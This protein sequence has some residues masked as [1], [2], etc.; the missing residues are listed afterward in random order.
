LP[1]GIK[2]EQT[3]GTLPIWIGRVTWSPSGELLA[4]PSGSGS[5]WLAKPHARKEALCIRNAHSGAVFTVAFGAN[6]ATIATGAED[7]WVKV[8]NTTTG[9]LLQ[10][11]HLKSPVYSVAF[12]SAGRHLAVGT[13]DRNVYVC[14]ASNVKLLRILGRHDDWVNCLAFAPGGRVLF[15]GSNDG[16]VHMWDVVGNRLLRKL[17]GHSRAVLGIAFHPDGSRLASASADATIKLWNGETGQVIATLEGHT[18]E[19]NCVTFACEGRV[20]ASKSLDNTFRVWNPDAGSCIAVISEP[21]ST[22]WAPGIAGHPSL[23]W[24]A[25]VGSK[26]NAPKDDPA[27][28]ATERDRVVHI[29][30][31]DPDVLR[32]NVTSPTITYTSAKVVLVGES[33]VGK[34]YLAHRIATGATPADGTIKSTHGMKFW[35]LEPDQLSSEVEVPAGERRDIVL[36]DMGGQ[37]EY[38]LI[39]QLFLHDTTVALVLLDPTRGTAAFKEVMTWNKH[40]DNQLRGRPAVKLL[41][42]SKLDEPS[43]TI[44]RKGL[45]R[46]RTDCGFAEYYETSALTGRGVT[47]MCN[48][49]AKAID[50]TGLGKTSRPKL[51]QFIRDEIEARRKRGDVVLHLAELYRALRVQPTDREARAVNAVT[52]QLA[53]QGV[54]ARSSVATGEPALVLQV[55]EVERY[56]GSLIVAARNNPRGVAAL[57]LAAIVRR[58]FALPGIPA[59]ERLPPDQ[60]LLVLECTVQLLLAHGICFKHEGLLVFPT[61]FASS[62]GD[63]AQ[64]MPHSVSLYYDFS[65]AIDNIYASL[66]AWL[67][68]A[69]DFGKVR[70]A[71]DRAE[72]EVQDS[73]LYGL[74]KVPRPGGFAHVDVFFGESV[75]ESQRRR[76]INF[77]DDHLN[78][79]GVDIREHVEVTCRCGKTFDEDTVRQRIARGERD[80]ICPICETRNRLSEGAKVARSEDPEV[81]KHTWALKTEIGLRREKST[82]SAVQVLAREARMKVGN[83]PIR[84]LHLSDLHFRAETPVRARLQWLSDDLRR[85]EGW[86]RR[87]IERLDYL[88]IS[89]DF[90]DRGKADG[91]ERAYEF[92][93]MLSQTFNLSAERCV[94]VPGNH[95]IRDTHDS[96]DWRTSATGLADGAWVQQ[97]AIVLARNKEKY[98]LRLK[99]FSDGFYHKF[100]QRPYPTDYSEQGLV[101]PFWETGLQF[102]TF[103]SCWEIDQFHRSR[104]G[105]HPEAVARALDEAQR[106]EVAARHSSEL[107]GRVLRIA[108]WHH[109]IAGPEQMV[110]TDFVGHLQNCGVKIALHG[111]V[112]ELR[113]DLVGQSRGKVLHVVGAGSFGASKDQRPDAMPRLYNLIELSRDLGSA[114]VHTRQQPKPDGPWKGWNEWPDPKGGDGAVSFYDIDLK[115][116]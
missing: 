19:I 79:H 113:R 106:Q 24:L 116:D 56:A 89:G 46:L 109:A 45:E 102:L 81:E 74:R 72:F 78:Q 25:T 3:I 48:A 95:D 107:K 115:T 112:H 82:T 5:V 47:E 43:E 10:M 67:V 14:D 18:G 32:N 33:N 44:D 12:D 59:E 41:V 98:P 35:P 55:Q 70:L 4:L 52:E 65:G 84:V 85:G 54:I 105:V 63:V 69:Q 110:N 57:E 40:L 93:S 11:F 49:A 111:D 29:W 50:W 21:A 38:R 60:E 91:F 26:W 2:L 88:V 114:R 58:G 36:W 80:V 101:I 92:V 37:D 34:S 76:F 77:V 108:V 103:N 68:L 23:P 100:L 75:P 17:H 6:G 20:L 27:S 15:S 94:F 28:L 73:G 97:G 66:V 22:F 8:W 86:G 1:P 99:Q 83:A 62:A 96:Y 90:T 30:K 9:E 61:C 71:G 7:E 51:F 53:T 104:S 16:T 39:H 31:L 42:G 64:K 13:A 87:G